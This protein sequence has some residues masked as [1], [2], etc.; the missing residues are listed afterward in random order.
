MTNFAC[1]V[2]NIRQLSDIR[3]FSYVKSIGQLRGTAKPLFAATEYGPY[4]GSICGY[5]FNG[6]LI[7]P[8]VFRVN[9]PVSFVYT[10]LFF[11]GRN[12]IFEP[13]S[14]LARRKSCSVLFDE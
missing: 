10:A 9:Y 13:N 5:N 4:F 1:S 6:S 7:E 11:A 8:L 14:L 2:S 3:H 12:L